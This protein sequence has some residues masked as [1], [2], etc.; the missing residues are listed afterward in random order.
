[1]SRKSRAVYFRRRFLARKSRENPPE[2]SAP[3]T[4]GSGAKSAENPP[5]CAK[6]SSKSRRASRLGVSGSHK[7]S[8]H[9]GGRVGSR[10]GAREVVRGAVSDGAA[11]NFA[12]SKRGS[13]TGNFAE[14]KRGPETVNI[15][16]LFCGTFR[17]PQKVPQNPPENLPTNRQKIPPENLPRKSAAKYAGKSREKLV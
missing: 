7:Y 6:N 11:L 15:S 17:R 8:F 2:F 16:G 9:A 12:E 13:E 5:K 1:M 3:K 10:L 4:P 14:S